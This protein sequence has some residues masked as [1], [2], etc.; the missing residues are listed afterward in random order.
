MWIL[1]RFLLRFESFVAPS[2]MNQFFAMNG[3]ICQYWLED[4][5][6][7]GERC[8]NLHAFP[9]QWAPIA[10]SVPRRADTSRN[11][12]QESVARPFSVGFL[13]LPDNT[14]CFG[15]CVE[16][17]PQL[18]VG[19]ERSPAIFPRDWS[20]VASR[21]KPAAFGRGNEKVLDPQVRRVLETTDCEVLSLVLFDSRSY[22]IS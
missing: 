20:A 13:T 1:A 22:R 21:S 6:H 8:W 17:R 19:N 16:P 4:R 9:N 5:C 10:S 14:R 3:Q 18:L 2:P 7:Y 11:S 15:Q 12:V